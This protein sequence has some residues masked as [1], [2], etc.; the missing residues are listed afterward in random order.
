MLWWALLDYILTLFQTVWKEKRVPL[1]WK[2]ALLVPVTKK[3]DLS[4]CDNWRDISLLD[5]MGKLFAMVL[6]D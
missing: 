5:M 3:G 2:D 1:E 6:N 4:S